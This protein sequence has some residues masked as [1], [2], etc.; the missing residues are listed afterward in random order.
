MKLGIS[1]VN[2]NINI[3]CMYRKICKRYL[4]TNT[5]NQFF[6]IFIYF[7]NQETYNVIPVTLSKNMVGFMYTYH[8]KGIVDKATQKMYT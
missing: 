4:F 6:I 8:W 1:V 2:K 7:N 5:F 3:K